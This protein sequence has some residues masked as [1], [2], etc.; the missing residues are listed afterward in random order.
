MHGVVDKLVTKLNQVG[1]GGDVLRQSHR[2]SSKAELSSIWLQDRICQNGQFV[3]LFR[4]GIFIGLSRVRTCK[5]MQ[6]FQFRAVLDP[7]VKHWVEVVRSSFFLKS[8]LLLM[9]LHHGLLVGPRIG[10]VITAGGCC[11]TVKLQNEIQN[12]LKLNKALAQLD[13]LLQW[14]RGKVHTK[15]DQ[16]AHTLCL[17]KMSNTLCNSSI[18]VKI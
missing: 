1:D 18:A 16:M 2:L 10:V 7:F 3:E 8:R 15:T 6:G 17:F 14:C 4:V 9:G 12:F 13:L 11:I 5:M